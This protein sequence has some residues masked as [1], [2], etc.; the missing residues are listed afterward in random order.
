MLARN[1]NP[2]L[3]VPREDYPAV[4]QNNGGR[5]GAPNTHD[6]HMHGVISENAV[7]KYAGKAITVSEDLHGK[8]SSV[9]ARFQQEACRLAERV[10]ERTGIESS[11]AATTGS[12]GGPGNDE[13]K[14]DSDGFKVL[15]AA[16]GE[17]WPMEDSDLRYQL[18]QLR[19]GLDVN[20]PR[21]MH[22]LMPPESSTY[23]KRLWLQVG[24]EP[25]VVSP[26]RTAGL[27]ELLF[28]VEH[29]PDYQ[30]QRAAAE[31][32]VIAR[33]AQGREMLVNNQKAID[34]FAELLVDPDMVAHV[35]ALVLNLAYSQIRNDPLV[36][37]MMD[38]G[39]IKRLAWALEF[40]GYDG[41][42]AALGAL[43]NFCINADICK[44][45]IVQIATIV[46]QLCRILDRADSALAWRAANV[47]TSLSMSEEP[48]T[49]HRKLVPGVVTCNTSQATS[50][51]GSL[52]CIHLQSAS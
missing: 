3:V 5:H 39:I 43:Q 38:A 30:R 13:W 7:E 31:L 17:T 14:K 41:R 42:E 33:D 26:A 21:H 52:C 46:P 4:P 10:I 45:V 23:A 50:W 27:L 25:N 6:Y 32:K 34:G 37:S 18:A 51:C 35:G 15:R 1:P 11:N 40:S 49:H 20:H 22:E 16:D 19:A 9:V 8:F 2:K 12:M 44:T 47:V 28:N 48:S 29:V 24:S 36:I